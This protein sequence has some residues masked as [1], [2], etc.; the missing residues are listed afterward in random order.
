MKIK[1]YQQG[2]EIAAPEQNQ[3]VDPMAQQGSNEQ[4][5]MMQQIAEIAGQIIEQLGPEGAAMLAQTIM[6]M[7]QSGQ[8]APMFKKGGK[9]VKKTKK[10]CGGGLMK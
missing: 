10:A 2:G 4:D 3:V 1:I 6:E 7:L 9:L 8:G 5:A